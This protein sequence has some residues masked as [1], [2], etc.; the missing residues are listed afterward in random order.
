MGR[1]PWVAAFFATLGLISA[2]CS[3]SKDKDE[4][5]A[6]T[7]QGGNLE[8][9][10]ECADAKCPSQTAA[11]DSSPTCR[12]LKACQLSCA[13]GDNVCG[14]ACTS[15]AA[16]DGPAILAAGNLLACAS[17]ACQGI[18][19][20]ASTPNTGV[21]GRAAGSGGSSSKG[22][23][24]SV[25]GGTTSLTGGVFQGTG[26]SAAPPAI[27]QRL[28]EWSVGCAV[29]GDSAVQGCNAAP[30]SQCK[31][32]CY[33]DATCNDYD[34]A[35]A[36]TTNTL[37]TCLVSCDITY[38]TGTPQPTCAN[39]AGKFASCGIL[40]EFECDDASAV[41]RCL[42]QCTLDHDCGEILDAFE[43]NIENDF[44]FC[45]D[46]CEANVGG[47][48]PNFVVDEGGYVT[49][50]HWHGYAWTDASGTG[51]TITPADFA[52]VP[53][54]GQ[55]C[56][57]GTV[58]GSTDYSSYAML[59]LSLAQESGDP[60]PDPTTWNPSGRGVAYNITNRAGTPLRLQI[61]APGGDTDPSLR[62]CADI[63][64]QSGDVFWHTFNTE[65]WEGGAG[66]A[67]DEVSSLASISVLVPGDLA[68]RAFDF[69]IYELIVD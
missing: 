55:L 35:K 13:A 65:C 17:T 61:Q 8:G 6:G 47:N 16:S 52:A 29:D 46:G 42:S 7:P 27:C 4:D 39:K 67:Y 23:T 11:C 1:G 40:T 20:F 21:G 63:S 69:C 28:L 30:L 3:G 54:G 48:S 2:S 59:G 36:G 34:E 12:T 60:A 62:W 44:V 25:T 37:S 31:A 57:S 45:Y 43:E 50:L 53:A 58:S 26:G 24:T 15:A 64:G 66:A 49:T 41:D 38:G 68:A 51:T 10:L 32:G 22:G 33:V 5:E 9:C 56:V 18:C 14:N 19:P